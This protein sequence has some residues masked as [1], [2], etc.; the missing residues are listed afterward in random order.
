MKKLFLVGACALFSVSLFAQSTDLQKFK[1]FRQIKDTVSSFEPLR[2][3]INCGFRQLYANPTEAANGDVITTLTSNTSTGLKVFRD[4][5][6]YGGQWATYVK[7][8]LAK[9]LDD[10]TLSTEA[11][12]AFELLNAMLAMNTMPVTAE[13]TPN[14]FYD[15]RK[16]FDA[17]YQIYPS[18]PYMLTFEE[19]FDMKSYNFL[20]HEERV[21]SYETR[22]NS[23]NEPV[24][25]HYNKIYKEHTE[26]FEMSF[27]S[28]SG[29]KVDL[30]KL[31]GKVVL[32][33]FWATWCG[34]CVA[35]MPHVK[36]VY[37]KYHKRGF[38]V[39]AISLD[40]DPARLKEYLKKNAIPWEQFFD[41]KG[42][43]NELAVKHGI[44]GV[45]TAYLLDRNGVIYTKNG[46]AEELDAA[47][48]ELFEKK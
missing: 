20:T 26:P 32:V 30:K 16:K 21:A 43:K 39:I 22:A 15:L 12:A 48:Q 13:L 34:P 42:W 38:E 11:K 35:E 41:G 37:K 27:T 31:K 28:F 45:P 4:K 1:T 23:E 40:D 8:E 46:R 47:M 44:T 36:E 24:S 17:V 25:T 18:L 29:K 10:N 5:I 2:E 7:E 14:H 9:K 19:K 33:D 6:E 3:I